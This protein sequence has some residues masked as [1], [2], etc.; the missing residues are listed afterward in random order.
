MKRYKQQFL[1]YEIPLEIG[2]SILYGKFLNKKATI[3]AFGKTDKGQPTI[4]TDTGK[5][6]VLLKIRIERL[7][8]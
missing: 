6:I 8:K 3:K 5:E 7:M 1:E 4:I 2:D